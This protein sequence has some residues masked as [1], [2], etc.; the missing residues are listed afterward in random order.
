MEKVFVDTSG[1]V[2]LF[3]ENDADHKKA[4][5][6]FEQLKE[7]K[8]LIYTSDYVIDETITTILVRG[9]HK[10]SVVA[11]SALFNSEI[12]KNIYVAPEYLESAW[13]LYQKYKDKEF[14]FTDVT[15]MTISKELNIKKAFSF[16]TDFQKMGFEVLG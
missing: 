9:S 10:Q 8:T 16:D 2:A 15:S 6:I 13:K 14:S 1:W 11:G 4:V 7:E 5:S 3:V 12:I